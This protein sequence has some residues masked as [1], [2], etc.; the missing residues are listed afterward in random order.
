VWGDQARFAV[1]LDDSDRRCR[2]SRTWRQAAVPGEE[3][4]APIWAVSLLRL[5]VWAEGEE[6]RHLDALGPEVQRRLLIKGRAPRSSIRSGY[7]RRHSTETR[8]ERAIIVTLGRV[9]LV[10]SQAAKMERED[11]LL[12]PR[13]RRLCPDLEPECFQL[14]FCEAWWCAVGLRRGLTGELAHCPLCGIPAV[15]TYR[16]SPPRLRRQAA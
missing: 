7:L 5:R 13:R 16:L 10:P 1:T 2:G 14:C 15:A 11:P 3:V 8:E 12:W 9:R 4:G 6:A